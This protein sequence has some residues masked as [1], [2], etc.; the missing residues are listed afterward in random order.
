[1][2]CELCGKQLETTFGSKCE[3]CQ[4]AIDDLVFDDDGRFTGYISEAEV[5]RNILRC[6]TPNATSEQTNTTLALN[7]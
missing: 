3:E 1:M 6:P 5:S 2:Q 7:G 4:A